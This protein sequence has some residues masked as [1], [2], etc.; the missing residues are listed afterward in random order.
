MKR[1]GWLAV[2]VALI[3]GLVLPAA[4]QQ[5][6]PNYTVTFNGDF[7]VVGGASDNTVDFL[8][9]RANGA[10]GS[11]FKDSFH[12][13]SNRFRLF[14]N[15]ESGDHHAGAQLALEIGDIIWGA[16]GGASAG[17]FNGTVG[18]APSRVATRGGGALGA[19]GVNVK[20]KHEYLWFDVP[21]VDNLRLTLGIQTLEFLTQPTEFLSDDI[22]GIK[23]DWKLDPVT[24]QLWF[25]RLGGPGGPDVNA[26]ENDAYVARVWIKPLPD[27]QFSVEGMVINAQCYDRQLATSAPTATPTIVGGAPT[28][29]VTPGTT[30]R[31][32]ACLKASFGDDFWVGGTVSGKLPAGIGLDLGLV[33]GQ[34]QLPGALGASRVAFKESGFGVDG[35]LT[36]P[37]NP[38]TVTVEGWYTTGDK[39]RAP[40]SNTEANGVKFQ[41]TTNGKKTCVN[42]FNPANGCFTGNG[43]GANGENGSPLIKNSDKL[44]QPEDQG[45]WYSRPLIAE[46]LLGMQTIG[47]PPEGAS[48]LYASKTGT[49]G[50]GGAAMLAILP[51]LTVGG[52]ATYVGASDADGLFGKNVFEFDGGVFYTVN[53]NMSI[54]GIAGYLVPDVGD[55][56]WGAA[57]RTIYRF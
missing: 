32:G 54:Q 24:V 25:G 38:V 9:T 19:D 53:A 23:A 39:N 41:P 37:V 22:A 5:A 33:Y 13:F 6:P 57:F 10:G 50:I 21:G 12:D 35:A 36:I 27:W 31:T 49:Y 34:R 18:G 7:R 47:G 30:A 14:T 51:S 4:A 20:T 46:I 1:G 26:Q 3:L 2:A 29:V 15:V 17:D 56:A 16:G 48:P 8:S 11:E 55:N 28:L 43:A 42:N 44:P 40:G 52:G 45:G